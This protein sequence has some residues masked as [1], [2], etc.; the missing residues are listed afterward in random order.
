MAL[1]ER[2]LEQGQ[3][4]A[5]IDLARYAAAGLDDPYALSS[6][7]RMQRRQGL[8]QQAAAS[9]ESCRERDEASERPSLAL[10][11]GLAFGHLGLAAEVRE[12]L[13]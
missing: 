13:R 8:N 5:A 4:E 12:E 1:A 6:L 11:R 10:D 7:A 9:L 2:E 3:G